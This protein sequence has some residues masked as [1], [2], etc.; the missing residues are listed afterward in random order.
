MRDGMNV[1]MHR[2]P[3][4]RG[5]RLPF[6]SVCNFHSARG[7]IAMSIHEHISESVEAHEIV[8]FKANHLNPLHATF[9]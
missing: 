9:S 6:N 8:T 3:E 5:A 4:L 1:T 2:R 7:Y